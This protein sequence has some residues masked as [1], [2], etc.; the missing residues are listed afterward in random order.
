MTISFPTIDP[1]SGRDV[2]LGLMLSSQFP[3]EED[4]VERF[5]D[6]IDQVHFARD[7]GFDGIFATQHYLAYPFQYLHPLAVLARLI[8]EIGDMRLGT[9][10][11]LAALGHPVDL[12]EQLATMDIMSNGRLMVGVGL[13]YRDIEFAAFGIGKKG[14][15]KRYLDNLDLMRQLWTAERVSTDLEYAQLDSVPIALRPV[16]RPHPPISMAAHSKSAI[17]R[18]ATMGIPWSAAAAHVDDEFFR[19]QVDIFRRACTEHGTEGL[20]LHVGH[21]LYVA[22]TE[23]AALDVVQRS[24]AVKYAAYREWGQDSVLPPSQTFDKEFEELRK[25]RFIIGDPA[26]CATRLQALIDDVQ[27]TQLTLRMSWPGMTHDEMMS[28]LDLFVQ[29]VLPL[30][31][32]LQSNT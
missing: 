15:L 30:I 11:S 24:L 14:R 6:Q 7:H 21:E 27:P 23:Q 25:G 1:P 19:Q 9:A 16:Q 32:A 12:A 18:T 17:E 2:F 10:V 5:S 26:S 29:E 20:A 4:P 28:G 8:P 22:R 3:V 13:G 31:P